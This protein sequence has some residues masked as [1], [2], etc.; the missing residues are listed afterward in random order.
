MMTQAQLRIVISGVVIFLLGFALVT[1]Y[2]YY[3]VQG[4]AMYK[5][6]RWTG[7]TWFITPQEIV[8]VPRLGNVAGLTTEQEKTTMSISQDTEERPKRSLAELAM[9][10]ERAKK[11]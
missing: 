5:V 9:E 6:D 8:P 2:G 3:A 1:R 7:R 11:Q 10:N 4:A